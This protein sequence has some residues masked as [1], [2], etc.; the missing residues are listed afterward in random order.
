MPRDGKRRRRLAPRVAAAAVTES[1]S[2]WG[3]LHE[4]LVQ[5]IAW[6]VLDTGDLRDY[7]RLRAACAH[8]SSSTASPRGR[9]VRDPRFHPRRWMMFPEGHGLFPGHPNL[10]GHVRFLNLSTGALVRAHL[11]AFFHGFAHVALDSADGLLVLYRARDTAVLLL[12]PFTGDVAEL[13][14]LASL[15][16]RAEPRWYWQRVGESAWLATALWRVSG[17]CVSISAAGD[18]T[19]MLALSSSSRNQLLLV[20]ATAGD[21]QWN[22][23]A[24][25]EFRGLW[26]W[27]AS[28]GKLYATRYLESS[29]GDVGRAGVYRI[30]PPRAEGSP[31][32]EKIAEFPPEASSFR[33][34]ECGIELML[35]GDTGTRMVIYRLDE[36]VAGKIAPVT[37]IGGHALFLGE[38]SICVMSTNF[39][40]ILGNSIIRW[41]D[42]LEVDELRDN[43]ID[44]EARELVAQYDM[45]NGAW[46]RAIDG[47]ITRPGPSPS[48]LIRHIY[49]CCFQFYW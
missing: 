47:H 6:R 15:F 43:G 26:R 36:L 20:Y 33:L 13:P 30:D 21:R 25:D 3:S 17:S 23:A 7:V 38:R 24:G 8:W 18:I 41:L 14:P 35:V 37:S 27:V 39:P 46:S 4:D 10:A 12:H 49:T 34:V 42:R 40:S 11:P 44:M 22:S 19:V 1:S 9:G 5:L 28:Q 48:S 45:V 2:A 29:G 31:S 16:P 32:L